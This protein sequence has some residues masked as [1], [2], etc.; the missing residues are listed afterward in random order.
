MTKE[1]ALMLMRV[2][3]QEKV[4]DKCPKSKEECT[5]K[6]STYRAMMAAHQALGHNILS[7]S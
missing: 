2:E 4:C 7:I 3:L 5:E 1:A 6:C